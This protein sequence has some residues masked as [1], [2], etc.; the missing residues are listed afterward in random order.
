MHSAFPDDAA[1]FER[2]EV[3]DEV[4]TID[5]EEFPAGTLVGK[6]QYKSDDLW[7]LVADGV[8]T[9]FSIGGEVSDAAEHESVPDDVRIPDSVDMADDA[10]VTE[11]V[12]GTINEVSDVDIPAVPRATYKGEQLGKALLDDVDSEEEFVAVMTEERGHNEDDAR[13]LYQYL[14][15]VR[16]KTRRRDALDKVGKPFESPDGAEFEDFEDCVESLMDGDGLSRPEAEQVCGAW[17][18]ETKTQET[19]MTDDTDDGIDDATK[20]QVIKSWLT[21]GTDDDVSPESGQSEAVGKASDEEEDDDD[22][23]DEEMAD[24]KHATGGETPDDTMTDD[25]E[26][27]DE[28]PAWAADLTETVE[29][30]D[31]RVSDIEADDEADA[32]KALDGAPEWATDLAEKVDSLDERVEAISKQSGHSQQLGKT[33]EETGEKSASGFTL[34]PRKAGGN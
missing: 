21:G 3:I 4:E 32:E 33:D 12:D 2:L 11:L 27:S 23:D 22:D 7:Q 31:K 17:Q 6:R 10:R 15:D 13:R 14:T 20:L 24:D 26:K 16:D 9:G 29:Q 5:G 30:I 34:D 8:L 25:T 28:P 19:T 18:E 1:E